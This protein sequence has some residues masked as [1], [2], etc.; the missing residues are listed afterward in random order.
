[1]QA[2]CG[3]YRMGTCIFNIFAWKIVW[4][5]VPAGSLLGKTNLTKIAQKPCKYSICGVFCF[6]CFTKYTKE[7]KIPVRDSGVDVIDL[8]ASDICIGIDG[9]KWIFTKRK[10]TDTPSRIPSYLLP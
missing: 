6:R 3:N 4:V 10:K 9:E 7:I 8:K 2:G 5:Q 1:M